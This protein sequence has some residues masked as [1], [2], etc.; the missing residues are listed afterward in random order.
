MFIFDNVLRISVLEE[1]KE[2]IRNHYQTMISLGF[3]GD[4]YSEW[5]SCRLLDIKEDKI[6]EIVKNFIESKIR[7]KLE[8]DSAQLQA[9]PI[10]SLSV[11]HKHKHARPGDYNSSLYLNDDFDGGEFFTKDILLKPTKNRLT[12]FDGSNILH[13]VNQVNRS[14]RFSMIFWWK[15]TKFF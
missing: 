12:F 7:V 13:G 8:C 11:Q 15:N 14:E 10:G 2:R 5:P 3:T 1:Y 6:V 4:D 9:W